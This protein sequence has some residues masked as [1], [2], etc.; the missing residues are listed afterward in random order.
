MSLS[1]WSTAVLE[2]IDGAAPAMISAWL[3]T[4]L[5]HGVLLFVVAALAARWMRSARMT[6]QLW[7]AALFGPLVTASLQLGAGFQPALGHWQLPTEPNARAV[8]EANSEPEQ[9]HAFKISSELELREATLVARLSSLTG[10][11]TELTGSGSSA[12]EITE[13]LPANSVTE[14]LRS[15]ARLG[16]AL[17]LLALV[18]GLAALTL[19]AALEAIRMQRLGQR[20]RLMSG[21]AIAV[22]D[23][24][25]S[26]AGLTRRVTL[27]V[28]DQGESPFATGL[29][30]PKIVLPARALEDLDPSS[31]RAMLAHEIG[32]VARLDPLWTAA[33]RSISA[34]FFFQPLN[35]VL[36]KRLDESAEYC[37]DEFAVN[38]TGNEV[39]LARCLATVAE[40]LVGSEARVRA[41]CPMAHKQSPLAERVDRILATDGEPA[42]PLGL[43]RGLGGA[44][45]VATAMAAPGFS[46]PATTATPKP[47][48]VELTLDASEAAAPLSTFGT[49]AASLKELQ[50]EVLAL[51]EMASERD[52]PERTI[53]RLAYLYE[54]A[55]TIS[56]LALSLQAEFDAAGEAESR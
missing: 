30:F 27:E 24:L 47:V 34:L 22:T 44:A 42:R 43:L 35:W 5:V 29:L 14:S 11:L 17:A 54:R 41:A 4:Y 8:V 56:A 1:Q 46:A 10:S 49:L 52:V 6:E 9:P 36:V 39:A 23:D 38:V 2:F 21:P 45:V 26:R 7:R 33:A 20:R 55:G 19:R 18:L 37:C 15:P 51:L 40:W 13:A 16:S 50:V 28:T 3:G 32:H 12:D 48:A 25:V 53:E 31:L